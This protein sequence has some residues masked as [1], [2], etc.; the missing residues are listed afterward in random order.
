MEA[1]GNLMANI[2]EKL[3][4]KRRLCPQI[5]QLIFDEIEFNDN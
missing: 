3:P 1:W 5:E 4:E 2:I